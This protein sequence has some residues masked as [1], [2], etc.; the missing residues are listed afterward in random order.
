MTTYTIKDH[1]I[2]MDG[3][4]V[5]IEQAVELL[6]TCERLMQKIKDMINAEDR[7]APTGSAR[8]F[9]RTPSTGP[10]DTCGGVSD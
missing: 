1:T 6:N 5:T 4:P 8:I 10:A 2:L 9:P 3:E 7:C